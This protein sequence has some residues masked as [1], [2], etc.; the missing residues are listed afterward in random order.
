MVYKSWRRVGNNLNG[1][2]DLDSIG[3]YRS[4]SDPMQ[5]VSGAIYKP[6]VHFEAPPSS[7]IQHE[8]ERFHFKALR[9]DTRSRK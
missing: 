9:S 6:V 2:T 8:M 1:V 5:V 3:V 7:A 4:L